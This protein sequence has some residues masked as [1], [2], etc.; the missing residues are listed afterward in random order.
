LVSIASSLCNTIKN[1][2]GGSRNYRDVLRWDV[3]CFV[4]WLSFCFNFHLWEN[5]FFG[6]AGFF[7]MYVWNGTA[8]PWMSKFMN[9]LYVQYARTY[10]LFLKKNRNHATSVVCVVIWILGPV[11]FSCIMLVLLMYRSNNY[12]GIVWYK[13][14]HK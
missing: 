2:A 10:V 11:S 4:R 9:K 6:G 13:Y 7:F 12:Q 1:G 3:R 8:V 5:S 14:P